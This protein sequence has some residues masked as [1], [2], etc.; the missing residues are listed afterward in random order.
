[1]DSEFHTLK[2]YQLLKTGAITESMEDYLEMLCRHM[3]DHDY[4]RIHLL[5]QRL[6][7]RPSSASKMVSKLRG[8]GLV[9]AEKYG[10]I[11]LTDEGRALGDYFLWRHGVLQRFFLPAQPHRRCVGAGGTGGAFFGQRNAEE[12]GEAD[13][14]NGKSGRIAGQRKRAV[15]RPPAIR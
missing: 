8:M 5:A 11:L 10:L 7:V 2:G 14:S 6:N 15:D 4:M 1:M 13:Y 9:R 3:R 12:F